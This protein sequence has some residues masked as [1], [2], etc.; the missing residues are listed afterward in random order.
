MTDYPHELWFFTMS[1]I[2]SHSYFLNRIS[3]LWYLG[4]LLIMRLCL[5]NVSVLFEVSSTLLN[6]HSPA[7]VPA[8]VRD[9][10]QASVQIS[11]LSFISFLGGIL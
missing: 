7:F 6:Q 2:L 4:Y 8:C 3:F 9:A 10:V 11:A 1:W 5:I